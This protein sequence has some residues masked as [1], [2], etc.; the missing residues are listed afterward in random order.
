MHYTSSKIREVIEHLGDG[1]IDEQRYRLGKSIEKPLFPTH[2]PEPNGQT[3]KFDQL[4]FL[5]NK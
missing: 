4:S 1:T 3:K 2:S 5:K